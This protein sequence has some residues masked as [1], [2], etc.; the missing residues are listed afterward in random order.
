MSQII[1][2]DR[3]KPTNPAA[4][5]L[6][7]FS[8]TPNSDLSWVDNGDRQTVIATADTGAGVTTFTIPTGGGT[9]AVLGTQQTF[10][11]RPIF[12]TTIGVGGVTPSTSGSGISF[13]ATQSASSDANTLDDYEEGTYTPT[14]VGSSHAGTPT[15]TSR[16]GRY[17][18]IG[19]VVF[20]QAIVYVSSNSGGTGRARISLPVAV[21]NA[22]NAASFFTWT[23]DV[24]WPSG[25]NCLFQA[26]SGTTSADLYSYGDNISS[27]GVTDLVGSYE[28]NGFY[29][30]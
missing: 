19:D 14:L 4:G 24:D 30:I 26:L 18:K 21:G 9:A 3:T 5:Q 28:L 25:S 29:F 16:S 20:V 7:L 1:F 23:T 8:F 22:G 27:A 12:S 17:T 15:Y 6:S 10:T 2:R 13:P 11:A